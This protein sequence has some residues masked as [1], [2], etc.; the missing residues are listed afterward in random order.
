METVK[1]TIIIKEI[2]WKQS[3][4]QTL[5]KGNRIFLSGEERKENKSE[6]KVTSVWT[7]RKEGKFIPYIR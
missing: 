6:L 1:E 4:Q 3:D 2:E 7:K 5:V